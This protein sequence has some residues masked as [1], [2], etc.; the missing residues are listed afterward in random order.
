MAYGHRALQWA[1]LF[2]AEDLGDEPHVGV[3]TDG[4]AVGGGD[5]CALLAAVLERE[6]AKEGN[7]SGIA[8]RGIHPNDAA[9]F[10]GTVACSPGLK[11]T[12]I[13]LHMWIIGMPFRE[14]Q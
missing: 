12:G 14:G 8:T 13:L 11:R 2:L 4:G 1:Q 10:P 3:H 9:L 7:A 6:E 5:P